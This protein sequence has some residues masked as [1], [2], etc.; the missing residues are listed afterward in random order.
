[1]AT[2]V[3]M[4][5]GTIL[6]FPDGMS[7][8]AMSAA[9]KGYWDENGAATTPAAQGATPAA[10][11][12]LS[13]ATGTEATGDRSIG[14]IFMDN[15]V[16]RD[17]G[18][19]SFGERLGSG[20]RAAGAGFARGVND[21]VNFPG[22]VAELG[23]DGIGMAANA[24]GAENDI[25]ALNVPDFGFSEDFTAHTPQTVV[26]EYLGTVGEFAPGG[27]TSG[28]RQFMR[29][30]VA[31]A[32]ASEGAGQATEGSRFE[33]VARL[34]GALSGGKLNDAAEAIISPNGGR[35]SA[36]TNDAVRTLDEAGIETTA[37]QRTRNT[38]LTRREM[39]TGRGERVLD[40]QNQQFTRAA[41]ER[42]GIQSDRVTPELLKDARDTIGGRMGDIV[43]GVDIPVSDEMLQ[44]LREVGEEYRLDTGI[45]G[46]KFERFADDIEEIVTSGGQLSAEQVRVWR[47]RLSKDT[48]HSDPDRKG[49]AIAALRI[50]DG[51][52]D[53]AIEGAK[54]PDAVAAL[55]TARQQYQ[56]VLAIGEASVRSSADTLLDGVLS[57]QA[58]DGIVVRQNRNAAIGGRRDL[59]G[60]TEAANGILRKPETSGTAENFL[61]A[62]NI[63]FSGVVPFARNNLEASKPGQAYLQNQLLDRNMDTASANMV[64]RIN[65]VAQTL[66][67]VVNA[68]S[69]EN[70][71]AR[72]RKTARDLMAA[73]YSPAQITELFGRG[74]DAVAAALEGQ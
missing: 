37:G 74:P 59:R 43:D 39:R 6:E 44:G 35:V 27:P 34:L 58:L 52:L 12:T 54:G 48:V 16:G 33:P 17:D 18:V 67:E 42:V 60:L 47:S 71:G 19:D 61:S 5:D 8:E 4:P 56:D 20:V 28:P 55:R 1:M 36:G 57:P 53:G 29:G 22:L 13:T 69:I 2:E 40:N 68:P 23:A 41:L 46:T 38:N 26:E 11:G 15:V 3:Q 49:A 24:V 70:I 45:S 51:A 63:P 73:G 25:G 9:A 65:P 7:D 64:N 14:D 72:R 30:V 10:Q 50:L 31:P 66:P 62:A 21:L 32:L